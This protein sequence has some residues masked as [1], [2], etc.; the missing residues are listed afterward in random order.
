M[1][2]AALVVMR[3]C[4][5]R[6]LVRC[7]I[8]ELVYNSR[9]VKRNEIKYW[10]LIVRGS[11]IVLLLVACHA[12]PASEE[13]PVLETAVLT[14]E[15]PQSIV[16]TPTALPPAT[17]TPMPTQSPVETAVIQPTRPLPTLQNPAHPDFINMADTAGVPLV[18]VDE[19]NTG[20]WQYP[21]DTFI[22]P[23][24]F[25]IHDNRAYLLDAGQILILNLAMP[26]QPVLLLKGGDVIEGVTVLEPLDLHAAPDGLLV[27][28]RAGD[29][30]RYD[31]QESAWH[32]DRYDRPIS[33]TSS[34]YYVALA[35]EGNAG[36]AL[37]RNGRYLLET[38][39]NYTMLYADGVQQSLWNLA[40]ARGIDIA[41][42]G[43]VVYVLAQNM[44]DTEAQLTKYEQTSKV[45]EFQPA[46]VIDQARQVLATETAVY[47]LDQNGKRLLIFTPQDGQ[48]QT[49]MQLPQ[50]DVI[51]AFGIHPETNQLLFAGKNRLYLFDRPGELANVPGQPLL[52]G[53]Q[54]H[55]FAVLHAITGF[56]PPIGW[57]I[58]TR[59]LQM[60]GAPRHYRLG[61]HQGADFYW[62]R[63]SQVFAAA[64]GIVIRATQDYEPPF[65]AA[66]YDMR[67]QSH[68][69]G[70][71]SEEALDFYR[72]RQVWIE[73][74]ND[75]V[76]RYI[77]LASVAWDLEEGQPVQQGQLVGTV[78]NSGSP[79]SLESP[80][81]DAHLHFELWLG[82]YYLG[83]FLRPVETRDWLSRILHH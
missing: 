62:A 46:T 15:V 36:T 78:G 79:A 77:H 21:E 69:L 19:D 23:L 41:A 51:S 29:V 43:D 71:T 60:P 16:E 74:E 47:I 5:W 25:A 7:R 42:A 8:C 70:Y 80:D 12:T 55:D 83:Q 33:D 75:I 59:D 35:G 45:G 27:L 18:V 4:E 52:T 67:T 72:G 1:P 10:W 57:D 31:W 65:P 22:H 63:D 24:A 56:A 9:V 58:T 66:F 13:V 11:L 3:S 50:D 32:V 26:E 76:S 34:H 81:S 2:L 28:D 44:H 17:P 64:D 61:V 54:P 37:V 73:H 40:E 49:L 20:V 38:S 6:G 82:D 53:I 48:L 39:Y 68:E 30:Y 14:K